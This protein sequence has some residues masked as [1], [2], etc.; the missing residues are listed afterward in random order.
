MLETY[1]KILVW[2]KDLK[3]YSKTGIRKK[4]KKKKETSLASSHVTFSFVFIFIYSLDTSYVTRHILMLAN[5]FSHLVFFYDCLLS[6]GRWLMG[7]SASK[8]PR[9]VSSLGGSKLHTS[10]TNQAIDARST[11]T[12]GAVRS[13]R[14]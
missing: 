12:T 5:F 7:R 2:N 4:N 11:I 14:I 13:A 3:T 1:N 8:S 6:L 10:S 9:T